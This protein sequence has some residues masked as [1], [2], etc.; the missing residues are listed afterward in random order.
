MIAYSSKS[1]TR[2]G[3]YAFSYRILGQR[4]SMQNIIKVQKYFGE[5]D[6]SYFVRKINFDSCDNLKKCWHFHFFAWVENISRSNKGEQN[7]TWRFFRRK[8]IFRS[9]CVSGLQG[10]FPVTLVTQ[11]AR[12]AANFLE[13]ALQ[14]FSTFQSCKEFQIFQSSCLNSFEKLILSR[15]MIQQ[16]HRG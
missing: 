15:L 12:S 14:S 8:K 11:L 7:W 10:L 2:S 6:S 13:S 1:R 4:A 3:N 5:T 16:S 9:I